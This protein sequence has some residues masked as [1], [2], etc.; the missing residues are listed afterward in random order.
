M[1]T[2]R[3]LESE[4]RPTDSAR[5]PSEVQAVVKHAVRD[6]IPSSFPTIRSMMASLVGLKRPLPQLN[7]TIPQE[8]DLHAD[9]VVVHVV[10]AHHHGGH[11]L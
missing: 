2:A 9:P 11:S 8:L 6:V 4:A 3:L 7:Y 1:P 5:N 10:M